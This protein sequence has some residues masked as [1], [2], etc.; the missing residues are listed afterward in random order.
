RVYRSFN[1]QYNQHVN[2]LP[3]LHSTPISNICLLI[4]KY[5][6]VESDCASRCTRTVVLTSEDKDILTLHSLETHITPRRSIRCTERD[7]E[8]VT[9]NLGGFKMS[10]LDLSEPDPQ[11]KSELHINTIN[12]GTGLHI[13]LLIIFFLKRQRLLAFKNRMQHRRV[14]SALVKRRR[15]VQSRHGEPLLPVVGDDL[16]PIKVHADLLLVRVSN[17]DVQGEFVDQ[18]PI[19]FVLVFGVCGG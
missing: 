16:D 15:G 3:Y 8:L 12:P 5:R 1:I 9:I 10:S 4:R 13:I 19:V 2:I 7:F 14:L 18:E 11:P 6:S 17:G